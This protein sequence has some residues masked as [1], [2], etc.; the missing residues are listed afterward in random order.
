VI[1]NSFS[2]RNRAKL[3]EL[4]NVLAKN[5]A[6]KASTGRFIFKETSNGS[7]KETSNESDSFESESKSS[8]M[9]RKRLLSSTGDDNKSKKNKKLDGKDGRLFNYLSLDRFQ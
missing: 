5:T 6:P 7:W 3:K 1:S 9:G 2:K 4:S 8:T